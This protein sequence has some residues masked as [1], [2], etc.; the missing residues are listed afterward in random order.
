MKIKNIAIIPARGGSKRIPRKNIKLFMGKPIMVYSIEAALQSRLFDEVMVSTDDEEIAKLARQHGANVPFMRSA[1]TAHDYATTADV[2]RE[3]LDCY[4]K[5]GREFDTVS[6]IYSTAPFISKEILQKAFNKMTKNKWDAIFPVV[7]FSYP[8]QRSLHFT[9]DS[10]IQ[11]KWPEHINSRSQDLETMYH[12]AGQFYISTVNAFIKY[13]D[14]WGE[15]T[16]A[17]IMEELQ[18]QDLDTETDWK[19]AEMKFQLLK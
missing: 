14:F 11:M 10:Y 1:Q 2:I 18:V 6:C 7:A 5:M 17:I 3:V 13:N 4:K 19:L 15:K 8:I 9:P 12:D 16:G